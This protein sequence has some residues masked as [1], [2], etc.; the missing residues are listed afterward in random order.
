MCRKDLVRNE[1]AFEP[2]FETK[3]EWYKQ[4]AMQTSS[5]FKGN[6]T[7]CKGGV[8]CTF[9]V[10]LRDSRELLWSELVFYHNAITAE[11]N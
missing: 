2:N 3:R 6:E 5:P 4:A 10:C 8:W 9:V 1:Y 11:A 7:G